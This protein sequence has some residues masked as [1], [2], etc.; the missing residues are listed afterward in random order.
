MPVKP[1]KR[2][3]KKQNFEPWEIQFMKEGPPEYEEQKKSPHRWAYL[4]GYE[5]LLRLKKEPDFNADD[6][7]WA[8][9]AYRN[10]EKPRSVESG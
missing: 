9:W 2:L 6:Y 7:P 3:K 8:T 1:L 4:D 5:I 10:K